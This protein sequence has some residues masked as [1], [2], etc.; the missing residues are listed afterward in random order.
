MT[1][2]IPSRDV[3]KNIDEVE[4]KVKM[5]GKKSGAIQVK[6]MPSGKTANDVRFIHQRI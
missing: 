1:T 3:F 5:I 6:Y 4:M 2:G